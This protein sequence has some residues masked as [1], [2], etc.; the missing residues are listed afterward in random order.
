M[1]LAIPARIES[2][3]DG[4]TTATADVLGLRRAVNLLLLADEPLDVGDWVLVHVGF[5]MSRISED[6]ARE[7]LELLEKLGAAAEA[8]EEAS[9]YGETTGTSP[10]NPG[11]PA[12]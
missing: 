6:R 10:P 5:A 1:C 12:P 11:G 8:H 7:Q 9:G 3:D 2:F 4:R